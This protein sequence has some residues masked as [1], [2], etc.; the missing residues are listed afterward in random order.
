M[1]VCWLGRGDML[2]LIWFWSVCIPKVQGTNPLP[3]TLL[4][5]GSQGQTF[6]IGNQGFPVIT[7]VGT[8]HL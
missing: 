6:S 7:F 2:I 4:K 3:E 1:G 5:L 8:G